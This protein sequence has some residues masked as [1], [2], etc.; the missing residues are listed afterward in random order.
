VLGSTTTRRPLPC[1]LAGSLYSDALDK[2][3]TAFRGHELREQSNVRREDA[4]RNGKGG[5]RG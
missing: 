3:I 2:A 5:R 1:P 4:R